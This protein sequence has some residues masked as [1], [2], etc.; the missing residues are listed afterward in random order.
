M[1]GRRVSVLGARRC[2]PRRALRIEALGLLADAGLASWLLE[3]RERLEAV[4]LARGRACP[5]Q[6]LPPPAQRVAR[7]ASRQ[8]EPGLPCVPTL[9]G[10]VGIVNAERRRVTPHREAG[11]F[12]RSRG[13]ARPEIAAMPVL[14]R[15]GGPGSQTR[16]LRA[17]DEGVR[18]G[19]I[20]ST[21]RLTRVRSRGPASC[22]LMRRT[23]PIAALSD[24][25][26]R[27]KS[28]DW[29]REWRRRE[30]NPRKVAA[31]S[32]LVSCPDSSPELRYFASSAMP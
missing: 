22:H 26:F 6:R 5:A 29:H 23:I 19:E 30:S 13:A 18:Y 25:S 17:D 27:S 24:Q 3:M 14:T 12:K 8:S 21:A 7:V 16:H 32:H 9:G 1:P 15:P 10:G 28:A 31:A 11:F 2:G 20:R 4:E